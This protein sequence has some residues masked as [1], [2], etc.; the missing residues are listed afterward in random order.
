M[1]DPEAP[2]ALPPPYVAPPERA[3]TPP[4]PWSPPIPTDGIAGKT[5]FCFY[6]TLTH[7]ALFF[8]ARFLALTWASN[9]SCP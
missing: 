2:N 9:E 5:C 7:G 6:L 3:D 1:T 8:L 4:P